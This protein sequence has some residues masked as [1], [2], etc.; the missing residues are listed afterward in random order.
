MRIFCGRVPE[1]LHL[2][3]MATTQD[4]DV[5]QPTNSSILGQVQSFFKK[6]SKRI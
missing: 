2:K 1:G 3:L 6:K 4:P 5:M